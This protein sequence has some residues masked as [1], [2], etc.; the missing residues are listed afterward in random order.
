MIDA[1]S[2]VL[3]AVRLSGAVFFTIE[4]SAPWVA[5]TPPQHEISQHIM[6]GV[7]HVV[8]YH[9]ITQGAC[10]ASLL[11]APPIRLQAGDLIAF[12]QGDPHTISSEPGMRGE[13][14]YGAFRAV[15]H[16]RL[17]IAVALDG[18]GAD[19]AQVICGFFGC[20]ARPFNPLLATLPR[21][22]HLAGSHQ[23]DS[24]ARRLVD[25]A[26]LESTASRAGSDCALSRLSELL[27]IEL[28][29]SYL[30]TLPPEQVG[31]FA[32]LRDLHIG[33]ALQKLHER[34]AQPW[35]LESLAREVGVSRSTLADRFVH[36]VGMPPIQYL[37]QWRIQLAAVRLRSS[38]ASIAEIADQVG[39]GSE[40]AL[41][42]AFKRCVGVAPA[43]YRRG[44][45]RLTSVSG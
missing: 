15:S 31:W 9:M 10:W 30:A 16:E 11:D 22:I 43:H 3:R 36:F 7:E 45:G 26:V 42:R 12:P 39:Y 1:L 4:G 2:D 19:R 13:P 18:G 28:V 17:P 40:A 41:S 33:R 21:V 5:E 8:E 20:D 38:R 24:V 29:R 32:G 23:P 25:M 14:Q 35:T 37:A 34:P 44:E 6:P 27:F